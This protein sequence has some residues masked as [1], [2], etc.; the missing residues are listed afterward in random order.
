MISCQKRLS[1]NHVIFTENKQIIFS[2]TVLEK[3]KYRA[4][5]P[6]AALRQINNL[7][8]SLSKIISLIV[9]G[10]I[11]ALFLTRFLVKRYQKLPEKDKQ[12][13]VTFSDTWL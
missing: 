6:F 2:T 9:V 7:P 10:I 12:K 5:P 4:Q 1:K 11:C 8:I 3:M 13:L